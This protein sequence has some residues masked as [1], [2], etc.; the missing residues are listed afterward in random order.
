[1]SM[2]SPRIDLYL[3]EM[4]CCENIV[5]R[6]MYLFHI[7]RQVL[8][9]NFGNNLETIPDHAMILLTPRNLQSQRHYKGAVYGNY[10]AKPRVNGDGDRDVQTFRAHNQ[11]SSYLEAADLVR[12]FLAEIGST[13]AVESSHF[14][15]TSFQPMIHNGKTTLHWQ[16][17]A[18]AN[19]CPY[20]AIAD[21]AIAPIIGT[22]P[23][24]FRL[25]KDAK[26]PQVNHQYTAK[27]TPQHKKAVSAQAAAEPEVDMI[28]MATE[29]A[30]S[31]K[32]F[33]AMRK[34]EN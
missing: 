25:P 2:S 22:L 28:A 34:T 32:R 33:N 12:V 14:M 9:D 13:N 27:G 29:L 10:V 19:P 23:N 6:Y 26:Q 21:V 17:A 11:Y 31:T 3:I 15:E 16:G 24:W 4:H 1:M 7:S 8:G 30:E 20:K 18:S 5:K